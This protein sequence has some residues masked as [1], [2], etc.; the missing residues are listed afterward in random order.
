VIF[1]CIV[2]WQLARGYFLNGIGVLQD[3]RNIKEVSTWFAFLVAPVNL[4]YFG[5]RLANNA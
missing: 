2:G 3:I 1:N 4:F 5:L